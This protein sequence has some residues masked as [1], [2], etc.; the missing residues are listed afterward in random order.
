DVEKSG[1][2]FKDKINLGL[3]LQGGVYLVMGVDFN[4]VYRETIER[5]ATSLEGRIK[6]KN[7]GMAKTEVFI[8]QGDDLISAVQGATQQ[9]LEDDPR[10]RLEFD[11]SKRDQI[12]DLVKE[13]FW[14]LRLTNE[15]AG[16]F[17]FG[18]ANDYRRDVRE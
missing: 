5:Q 13:E 4:R 6:E 7:F 16:K 3:D 18:L 15:S 9:K 8:P 12:Y 1:F 17:E 11:A 10:F 2:F 14:T